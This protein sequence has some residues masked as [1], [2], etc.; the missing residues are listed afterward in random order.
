MTFPAETLPD[1]S[2]FY[3]HHY[4]WATT[5]ALYG[6]AALWDEKPAQVVVSAFLVV[7]FQGFL[8]VWIWHPALGAILALVGVVVPITIIASDRVI[9]D[10]DGP[11]SPSRWPPS[12]R[13]WTG[14]IVLFTLIALDDV[15]SHAFGL[16]TPLDWFWEAVVLPSLPT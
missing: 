10:S 6:S 9:P 14:W 16:W 7:G 8:F 2:T 4:I 11:V 15:L 1:G 13:F 5:L 12:S 3:L